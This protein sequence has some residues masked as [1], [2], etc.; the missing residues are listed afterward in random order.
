MTDAERRLTY[1]EAQV[2]HPNLQLRALF[3]LLYA[4]ALEVLRT[5]IVRE[6]GEET[7]DGRTE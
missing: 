7:K 1:A 6:Y 4:P 3:A 5:T 2:I